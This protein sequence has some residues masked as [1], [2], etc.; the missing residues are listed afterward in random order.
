MTDSAGTTPQSGLSPLLPGDPEHV[1]PYRLLGRLGEGGM[2]IVYLGRGASGRSVAV[3]VLHPD[4]VR[5]REA[6]ERFQR[7]VRLATRVADAFTAPVL[8]SGED[9][10]RVWMVTS[11]IPGLSLQQSVRDYGPLPP[12][13]LRTLWYGLLQALRSVHEAGVVHRDIKPSNV[14]LT[15][16]GPRLI[17][18]GI[19]ML[20]DTATTN[21]TATGHLV[22]TPSYMSPEHVQGQLV[23]PPAD[24]FALGSVM[25]FAASGQAPFQGSGLVQVIFDVVNGEPQLSGL[26]DDLAAVVRTCLHKDPSY[27]PRAAE[28][29]GQ[30]PVADITRAKSQMEQGSWLPAAIARASLTRAQSVLDLDEP[31]ASTTRLRPPPTA[32]ETSPSVVTEEQTAVPEP[33]DGEA[34]MIQAPEDAVPDGCRPPVP[35]TNP[36]RLPSP[37][38]KLSEEPPAAL[39]LPSSPLPPAPPN[40]PE[41]GPAP[42]VPFAQPRATAWP[43]GDDGDGDSEGADPT[44][45][46]T[47]AIL[48]ADLPPPPKLGARPGWRRRLGPRREGR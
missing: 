8:D 39:G 13:S 10:D 38:T 34:A 14:L 3:K 37:S 43:A 11:F 29:M 48:G 23:G 30:F 20:T 41:N 42:A 31:Y 6:R 1:G 19:S 17:D 45:R 9:G 7:E 12:D 46:P 2:G 36:W 24:V 33:P 4:Q 25:V 40:P 47:T 22:G 32:H 15:T 35:P 28:M 44:V 27:R 16:Q 18:F 26:P 5:D 21:I